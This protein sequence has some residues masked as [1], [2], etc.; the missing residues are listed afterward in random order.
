[1]QSL[2][3]SLVQRQISKGSCFFAIVNCQA[4]HCSC[5]VLPSPTY[6]EHFWFPLH[7]VHNNFVPLTCACTHQDLDLGPATTRHFQAWIAAHVQLH[8]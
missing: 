3:H 2:E 7:P 5:P 8:L 4:S 6:F 1:L